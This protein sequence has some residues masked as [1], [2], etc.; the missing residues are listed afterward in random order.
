MPEPCCVPA[1]DQAAFRLADL[2]GWQVWVAGTLLQPFRAM[3]F[4]DGRIKP[5]VDAESKYSAM[6]VHDPI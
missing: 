5:A 6:C 2:N 1:L 4:T 3:D